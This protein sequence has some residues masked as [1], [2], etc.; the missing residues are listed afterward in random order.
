MRC[1][2]CGA[3]P[4]ESA[5]FCTACGAGPLGELEA[6]EPFAVGH[7]AQDVARSSGTPTE[8]ILDVPL[9]AEP[10]L[11]APR[12]PVLPAHPPT[13]VKR[14]IGEEREEWL[15]SVWGQTLGARP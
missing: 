14:M 8:P 15:S 3:I 12:R 6:A 4:V 1:S 7:W 9:P 2:A 10:R 13:P 5:T 11:P